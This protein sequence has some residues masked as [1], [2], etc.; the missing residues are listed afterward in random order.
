MGLLARYAKDYPHIPY[1]IKLNSKTNLI[2]KEYKDPF[3]TCW[4]DFEHIINFKNQTGLN[5]V[6][7]GY[8]IYVGSWYESA[9]FEQA[10][11]LVYEAHQEGLVTVLWIYM[12]GR[13]IKDS[14]NIHLN[15]GGA[16]VGLCL[17]TDFIKIIC[18]SDA[19][20]NQDMEAYKEVVKAAGRAGI[21]C[22]GGS[23]QTPEKFLKN[24]YDQVHVAGTRGCAVGRNI[25]QRTLDESVRMANAISAIVMY[26]Y[27][28]E[29]ALAVFAG[30]KQLEVK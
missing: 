4:Y 10:A 12:R 14:E 1:L 7:V 5:I 22:V 25:Y 19:K 6:G 13:S 11:R 30:H 26:D 18:P 21:I 3:S 28:Y 2:K 24:L 20:G 9:M 17:G 29:D 15:A 27:S 8:T 16:G 23:K